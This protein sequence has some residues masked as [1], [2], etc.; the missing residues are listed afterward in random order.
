MLELNP[1]TMPR[2]LVNQSF[3]TRVAHQGGARRKQLHRRAA[4]NSELAGEVAPAAGADHP[5]GGQQIVAMC[6][7]ETWAV[8][9][10][11]RLVRGAYPFAELSR[12][13]LEGVLRHARRPLPVRRV[14]RAAAAGGVGSRRWDGARPRRGPLAGGAERGHDP[15]PGPLRRVLPD[16]ARVG[17]LDEEMVYEAPRARPSCSARPPGASRRSPATG[18]S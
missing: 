8:D 5:Q 16:G 18:S 1:E 6:S 13:Q 14:R 7:G 2:L 15:R 11:E 12:E 9:D 4:A 17:E 3:Y 10:L